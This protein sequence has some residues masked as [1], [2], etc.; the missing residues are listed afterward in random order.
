MKTQIYY[1]RNAAIQ[2]QRIFT[3]VSPGRTIAQFINV[4]HQFAEV[5]LIEPAY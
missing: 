3:F 2:S 5:T 1:V 4:A